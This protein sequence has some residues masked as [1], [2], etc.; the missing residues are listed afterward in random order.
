MSDPQ[1]LTIGRAD[2]NVIYQAIG[3][4]PGACAYHGTN[5][6]FL[7]LE[8]NGT[9]RCESCRSPWYRREALGVIRRVR[10]AAERAPVSSPPAR[11]GQLPPEAIHGYN[12][13][14]AEGAAS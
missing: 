11:R 1:T 14:H 7:G 5:F 3:R 6:E 8:P 12:Q 9:P 10:E 13:L 4:L 2:L